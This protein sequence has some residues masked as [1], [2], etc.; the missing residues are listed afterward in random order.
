MLDL[1]T[2]GLAPGAIIRSIGAVTF[3]LDGR[4]N[5]DQY[6]SYYA[7]ITHESCVEAGL[8]ADQST[9]D[10]W[11]AQP[12]ATQDIFLRDPV[13]LKDALL[14]LISFWNH[15]DGV[16]VWSQGAAFDVVLLEH[17][18][19]AVGLRAPWRFYNVRDTRTAYQLF[20]FDYHAEHR[21]GIEHYALDDCYHQA[22]C[23]REAIAWY[24]AIA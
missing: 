21:E 15:V 9:I 16:E 7:N 8:T 24:H 20:D 11:A 14:G 3:D 17:A 22:K 19:K 2:M 10:W 18:F 13:A 12:Q 6:A 4:L 5:A 23:V 1:E